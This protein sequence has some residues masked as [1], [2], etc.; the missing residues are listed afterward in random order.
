MRRRLTVPSEWAVEGT[1][2]GVKRPMRL[3]R[4]GF[5]TVS[6]IRDFSQFCA[7]QTPNTPLGRRSHVGALTT[8]EAECCVEVVLDLL[9]VVL[10]KWKNTP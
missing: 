6:Q 8:H 10:A 2:A 5:L 4:W 3:K 1:R 9:A 7:I